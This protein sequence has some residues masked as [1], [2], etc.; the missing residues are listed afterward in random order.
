MSKKQLFLLSGKKQSGKDTIGEYFVKNYNFKKYFFSDALKTESS[1]ILSRLTGYTS[2]YIKYHF[3]YNDFK[4]EI[5]PYRH[6]KKNRTNR[7]F[8]Q[9]LGSDW[10]KE[11]FNDSLWSDILCE[12]ILLQEEDSDFSN[13]VV[14]TDCRF[15]DEIDNIKEK[16]SKYYDIIILRVNRTYNYPLLKK[17]KLW[18]KRDKHI[19]EI[20]LDKYKGFDYVV[21]NDSSLNDLYAKVDKIFFYK[22]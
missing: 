4:N 11:F 1:V 15:I 18:L 22:K 2:D 17:F 19:S 9:K 21:T 6:N 16:L 12:K 14:V 5:I 13:N 10:F 3:E 7:E 20:A 8:L